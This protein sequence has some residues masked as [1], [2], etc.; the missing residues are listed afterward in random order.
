MSKIGHF[1]CKT[2]RGG[3]GEG[4]FLLSPRLYKRAISIRTALDLL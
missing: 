1:W 2:G 4:R 3:G